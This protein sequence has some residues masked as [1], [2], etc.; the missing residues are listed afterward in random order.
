MNQVAWDYE[1]DVDP[2]HYHIY[3]LG[4]PLADGFDD[5]ITLTLPVTDE[6]TA[7]VRIIIDAL[8]RLSNRN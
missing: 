3:F 8:E 1:R 2:P 4:G 5:N 6:N 7:D